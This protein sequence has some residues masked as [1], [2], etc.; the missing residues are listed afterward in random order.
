[1]RY[2]YSSI[3]KYLECPAAFKYRYI[4]K[5][6]EPTSAAMDRGTRLHKLAEDYMNAD[7]S[8]PVPYALKKIGISLYQM[9]QRHYQ[10]ES[11]WLVDHEWNLV[12]DENKAMLKAVIDIHRLDKDVL[13][14]HDY[15]SGREYPSHRDQLELYSAIGL[16]IYPDAKRVESSA[17]YIDTGHEGSQRSIIRE[18]LPHILQRWDRDIGRMESD[19]EFSPTPGGH[20][21]R[22]AHSSKNKG[23][24][25]AWR[26][27]NHDA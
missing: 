5:L 13:R 26:G 17:I 19:T 23:P 27:L 4:L 1:M 10:T 6:P 16:C 7:F 14:I 21:E 24:C 25:D 9:R 3:K 2:S 22:C 18:M 8:V 15:K 11:T 12:E 20:C